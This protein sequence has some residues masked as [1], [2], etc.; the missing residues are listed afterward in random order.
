MQ[1]ERFVAAGGNRKSMEDN[2]GSPDKGPGNRPAGAELYQRVLQ[3]ID[4]AGGALPF[5]EFMD[6]VLYDPQFGY[7]STDTEKFG[8][9]GDFV[10]APELS[11][12]LA[13][14]IAR[15]VDAT[16]VQTGGGCILEIG[17]GTGRLAADLLG[18]VSEPDAVTRYQILERSA[19]LQQ[20]Q[21]SLLAAEVPHWMDRVSWIDAL[22]ESGFRGVM[23]ANELLDAMTVHR[24]QMTASGLAEIHVVRDRDG[25]AESLGQPVTARLAP[26]VD[27]LDLPP[28]YRTEVGLPRQDWVA[29]AG[30]AIECGVL[31]LIDYGY[32]RGEY[33]HPAR[34]DGTLLCHY[35]HQ[36][37]ANPYLHLGQQD[38]TAHVE[39]TGVAEAAQARGLDILGFT[40]QAGFLLDSGVL[41]STGGFPA[42]DPLGS[43][44]FSQHLKRLLLPGQMGEVFKVMLAGRGVEQPLPGFG[45]LDQRR[46]L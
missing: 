29:A 35:R 15:V 3:Q 7:Y 8:A 25:L 40:T 1:G 9:A 43:M 23:V 12:L 21:R 44:Q 18:A 22:P 37:H 14:S 42:D 34:S 28:G 46:R 33:Y 19:D 31:L 26:F 24:V 30:A 17:A 5:V 20:R 13:R 10:T 39:F 32:P 2:D 4:A 16:L 38:I 41:E 36:A 27:A 45:M 6:R 11:P